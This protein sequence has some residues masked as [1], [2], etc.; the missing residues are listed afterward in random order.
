MVRYTSRWSFDREMGIAS[1]QYKIIL[2]T[3]QI[4]L[5]LVTLL[6]ILRL[7]DERRRVPV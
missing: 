5:D 7:P 2:C 4:S 3:V 1:A 6:Q